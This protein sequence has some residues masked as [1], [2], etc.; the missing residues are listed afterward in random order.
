VV[1]DGFEL[2]AGY[3]LAFGKLELDLHNDYELVEVIDQPSK[4]SVCVQLRRVS[5]AWVRETL[6]RGIVLKFDQVSRF[7]RKP[8]NSELAA[9][10]RTISFMGFL[11]PEDETMAGFLDD[12]TDPSQDLIIGMEDG[13]AFKVHAARVTMLVD[14]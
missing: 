3:I 11:H 10:R 2:R 14:A 13:S 8:G 9:D 7:I 6:P 1:L 4:T 12:L 5:G